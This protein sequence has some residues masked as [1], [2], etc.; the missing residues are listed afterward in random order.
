MKTQPTP[1][2]AQLFEAVIK[3][4]DLENAARQS[5][6]RELKGAPPMQTMRDIVNIEANAQRAQG[7]KFKPQTITEAAKLLRDYALTQFFEEVRQN[8][9]GETIDVFCRRWFDKINGNSYFSLSIAIPNADGWRVFNVPFSY[10]YGSHPEH[11]AFRILSDKG[12]FTGE[13]YDNR[14]KIR[15]ID[16]GY[17]LQRDLYQGIYF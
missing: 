11:E 8:W 15:F 3:D 12:F 4:R 2:A 6:T 7:A 10:G 9:S 14:D 13:R 16:H 17:G 1:Q 5:I